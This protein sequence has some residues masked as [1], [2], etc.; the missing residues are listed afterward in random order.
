MIGD[1]IARWFNAS[2]AYPDV[3]AS[4]TGLPVTNVRKNGSD[5]E[6]GVSRTQKVIDE[7]RPMFLVL[8]PGTSNAGDAGR[9]FPA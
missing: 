9:A 6:F 5:A 2:I 7:F 3:M 4:L 8:I 1:S